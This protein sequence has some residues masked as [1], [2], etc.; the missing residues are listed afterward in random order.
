MYFLIALR[1]IMNLFMFML[2]LK[3]WIL[4]LNVVL[5]RF[6]FMIIGFKRLRIRIFKKELYW[7]EKF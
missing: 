4:V 5:K 7:Y 2:L 1:M 6:G 3:R